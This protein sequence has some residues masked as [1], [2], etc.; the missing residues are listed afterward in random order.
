MPCLQSYVVTTA[1]I[2]GNGRPRQGSEKLRG[3]KLERRTVPQAKLK[4][5]G[6]A[7]FDDAEGS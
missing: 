2:S 1:G 4:K 3:L 7:A 6:P 5:P